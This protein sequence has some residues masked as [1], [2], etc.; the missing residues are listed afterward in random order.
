[1]EHWLYRY[2]LGNVED[3]TFDRYENTYIHHIKDTI[4]NKQLGSIKANDIQILLD[5]KMGKRD[6]LGY[7]KGQKALSYSSTIKIKELL[8]QCFKHAVK[9]KEMDFNPAELVVMP[10]RKL[11]PV[12]TKEAYSLTDD[13]MI[14]IKDI[15]DKLRKNGQPFYR[16]AWVYMVMMNTGLRVGEI[17]ALEWDDVDF[18]RNIIKV[19]EAVQ[20]NV[21]VRD[22]NGKSIN[23][24]HSPVTDTKT[25][26]GMRP[27]SLNDTAITYLTLLKEYAEKHNI[28]TKHVAY[29]DKGTR[30][31]ARNLQRTLDIVADKANIP[32]L[33]LHILRHT[34]GSTLL[35]KGVDISVV[36]ELMG[37]ANISITY[38]TYIHIIKEQKAEAVKLLDLI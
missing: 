24:R 20:S 18:D 21:K 3:T 29:T 7:C 17:I 19:Y 28:K 4:G 2:T 9:H 31:S 30:V 15:A 25:E 33:G 5:A 27:V 26:E 38:K 34:F 8:N 11:Y 10:K 13:E 1:M 22:E 36:S 14:A 37:H 6:E 32:H 16:Y 23:K 12:K 35:R